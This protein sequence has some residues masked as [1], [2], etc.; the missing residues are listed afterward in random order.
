MFDYTADD[1]LKTLAEVGVDY[2]QVGDEL[3]CHHCPFCEADRVERSDHF[4][5]QA[6]DL[7][8]HC[9]KCDAG[10]NLYTFRRELG[11]DVE[12]PKI[13]RRPDREY[14]EK[15]SDV[16]D[17]YY[18]AY[19]KRRGIPARILKKYE[20]GKT[21][22]NDIGAC[23]TYRY[24]DCDGE[25]AN[26]KYVNGKKEMRQEKDAKRIYYGLQFVDFGEQVLI[27]TEGEDDCHALAALD[28]ENVVSVPDGAQSYTEAM[29][30]VNKRFKKIFLVYDN[31]DAG[32]KGAEK[33]ARKAGEWKCYN[34][35]LPYKDSRECLMRGMSKEKFQQ[36]FVDAKPFDTNVFLRPALNIRERISRF[37]R[38][39]R[40]NF[41]GI[42]TGYAP[43]DEI[44]GGLRKGDV[45]TVVANP[46]CFK[47]TT[48]M[49]I[50]S[51]SLE[52]TMGGIAIFYS[53]EMHIESEIERE[54]QIT[55][56]KKS[57]DL[58][59]AV[60]DKT[61]EWLEMKR[62]VTYGHLGRLYVS[63]ENN[64]D[65]EG[66]IRIT[67]R[68]EEISGS[69]CRLI[70]IDYLDFVK[71][72]NAK[73]YDAVRENMNAIKVKI[74]RGLG[75]PVIVLAQTNR[76]S[77]DADA[78]IGMRSGKGGTGLES[79]SDFMLGLW[80]VDDRVVGR[81]T[82]HRRIDSGYG[83]GVYPY[84]SLEYEKT[85]YR[86]K[87]MNYCERPR[88]QNDRTDPDVAYV[89]PPSRNYGNY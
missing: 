44:T 24:V 6:V 83:G 37:E 50:L 60:K 42:K 20:V 67:K 43:I 81:I 15:I 2:R 30:D 29:G 22:R 52:N 79:A 70:G 47:T 62:R 31:D 9:V 17:E 66:I 12:T 38:E 41:E 1:L 49:N 56:G 77:M 10:G 18:A 73:E 85:T 57:Y 39:C 51:G 69:D 74:A 89:R 48:L 33:F 34:V 63:D 71:S 65:I 36:C 14:V 82:K 54:L 11:L 68:T 19:E 78:E 80:L 61:E 53:L 7:V 27:V 55:T 21:V 45:F 5:F 32:Q 23:R 13:Y 75:V 58:R 35:L 72:G 4:S 28:F 64:V 87:E 25:T 84:V 86:L 59:M 8:Y 40:T 16:R 3:Q 26:I 76:L 88:P 46:G